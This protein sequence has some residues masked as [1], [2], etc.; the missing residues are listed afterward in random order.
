[1][2]SSPAS[3]SDPSAD[4]S[5]DESPS[6]SEKRPST[7]RG[8][9]GGDRKPNDPKAKSTAVWIIL[10][11]LAAI[12][13]GL[14][15]L[16]ELSGNEK[17]LSLTELEQGLEDGTYN[18]QT[19]HDLV[20]TES[21]I[22]WSNRP[23]KISEVT[24]NTDDDRPADESVDESADSAATGPEPV[25]T[26]DFK[27]FSVPLMGFAPETRTAINEKLREAG[28]EVRG[29]S[30]KLPWNSIVGG[31][32]MLTIIG[33]VLFSLLK[34]TAAGNPLSFGRSRG[35]MYADDDV[36]FTFDDVAGQ[37]EAVEELKEIVEFLKTPEKY[38][39]LG[40]RIPK[41]VLLVG[42]PGTGK[43]LL[44]KAVAG[45][46]GVP[47]FSLSGSDFVEM[48]VGVGAARVRDMFQQAVAKSPSIIFIDELDALGKAR[49]G[50]MPG[51]HDE[52]EQTLNAL[53][54]EMDGFESEESVIVMGATNRPETL[55]PALMRPGRFDRNV[56]VDRPDYKGREA[57]LR[58][59]GAKRELAPE[60]DLARL[61]KLTPGFVG[62]DLENLCN[63]AALLAARA[64][65]SAV[66]NAEMEEA[67]E[68]VVAG[69]EKTSKVIQ[70]DEKVRVAYHECGHALVACVLPNT[71]PVH[72]ISII[73]RGLGALGYTLQRPEE[74][75]HLVTVSEIRNRICC[76]L[77]G[78]AAE[79]TVFEEASTG[80]SNDLERATDMARRM[81]TE[82]G[83]SR[84]L[85][86][87]NYA[88]AGRS[89]FLPGAGGGGSDAMASEKTLREIDEEIKRIIDECMVT[90]R[91]IMRD[92]RPALERMTAELLEIEVMDAT[93]LAA[94]L[95]ECGVPTR[96]EATDPDQ[97][98]IVSPPDASLSDTT[99]P[100][101]V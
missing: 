73:P 98:M 17:T 26:A 53:L 14:L 46:A 44:A 71:D 81:V 43:T 88:K 38:S 62:A 8:K 75:R 51:G 15:G 59:H 25:G 83:M 56:L 61:A 3:P 27:R 58:V 93:Q 91:E 48:Y 94:I 99:R 77:G 18:A 84:K 66:G 76:L 60:V 33:L 96:G 86:R 64:G 85:G 32:L 5:S 22:R 45:E 100:S 90:A 78:I 72:K 2:S 70:Q 24:G 50:G 49:G 16:Q 31:L 11:C 42:P 19:V 82:F 13:V 23:L 36:P 87:V 97:G 95:V 79:D 39:A 67:I 12:L 7:D 69:L 6:Q 10:V 47:F 4:T 52:R 68:R 41:G 28:I 92:H 35:K 34:Y 30:A 101:A 63:E 89:P 74:D 54:V 29:S 40:G 21:E 55:D 9:P 1:M 57:I 65:K 80:A 20:F 37:D